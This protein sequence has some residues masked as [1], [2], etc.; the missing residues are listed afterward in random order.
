[1]EKHWNKNKISLIIFFISIYCGVRRLD[2]LQGKTDISRNS[3][4][5]I[6]NPFR[7]SICFSVFAYLCYSVER[8]L[9]FIL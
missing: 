2:C 6:F 8:G 7:R 9:T 3:N 5:Y 4:R 1:M